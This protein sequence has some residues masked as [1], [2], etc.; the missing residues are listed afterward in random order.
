MQTVITL[1]KALSAQDIAGNWQG[2][3]VTAYGN[4]IYDFT[5]NADGTGTGTYVD[6]AGTYPSD[7]DITAVT[8]NGNTVTVTYLSYTM[9]YEIVFTY[10]NGVMTSDMGAMWGALTVEKK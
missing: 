6:E 4:Y 10:E 1:N 7:M 2:T 8:V 5:I 3:E 9:E